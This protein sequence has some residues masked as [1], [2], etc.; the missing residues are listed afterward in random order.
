MKLLNE[1]INEV[2]GL[3]KEEPLPRQFNIDISRHI[4]PNYVS[5]DEIRIDIHQSINKIKSRDQIK[6]LI[7]EY[8][9]RYGKL[10]E[11]I[12]LYME[13]K[14]L[15]FLFKSRGVESFKEKQDEVTFNF[16]LDTSLKI[17]KMKFDFMFNKEFDVLKFEFINNK[18]HV[19]YKNKLMNKSYIYLFTKFL[20]QINV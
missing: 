7:E 3:V 13:E 14:Y 1:A 11:D 4:S 19:K 20:E 15:E 12:L 16:D 18:V 9:D 10:S 5:D 17:V 6:A 2:K 8:T